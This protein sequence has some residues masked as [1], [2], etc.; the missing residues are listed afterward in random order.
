M[1]RNI[2]ELEECN[3]DMLINDEGTPL[4]MP[5]LHKEMHA[6]L[7]VSTPIVAYLCSTSF[8]LAW[9]DYFPSLSL[10]IKSLSA[11]T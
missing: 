1:P 10:S 4:N 3:Y 2:F 7:V 11:E 5:Q 8:M 9:M 6:I